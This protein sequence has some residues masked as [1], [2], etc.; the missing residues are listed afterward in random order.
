MN[1]SEK[2]RQHQTQSCKAVSNTHKSCSCAL[3]S[4]TLPYWY[5]PSA[6]VSNTHKSCSCALR[7]L[8]LST[9]QTFC[10]R[11]VVAAAGIGH[12]HCQLLYVWRCRIGCG[13]TEQEQC[14]V[15]CELHANTHTTLLR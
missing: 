4:L 5:K 12:W 13:S 3:R 9:A 10:V 15:Q 14:F 8:T 11:L 6:T 7:S 2:C 1:Q